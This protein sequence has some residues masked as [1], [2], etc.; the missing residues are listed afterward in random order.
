MQHRLR[1]AS[2]SIWL[3]LLLLLL[4]CLAVQ[5]LHAYNLQTVDVQYYVQATSEWAV[6]EGS[7]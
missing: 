2:C 1:R 4:L 7:A 3:L 5:Y 6:A